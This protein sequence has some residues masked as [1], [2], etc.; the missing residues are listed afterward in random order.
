MTKKNHS[1]M[2]NHISA[3]PEYFFATITIFTEIISLAYVSKNFWEYFVNEQREKYKTPF[4]ANVIR[5]TT[6]MQIVRILYHMFITRLVSFFSEN[7]VIRAMDL[8][9]RFISLFKNFIFYQIIYQIN[10][11][12]QAFCYI[13]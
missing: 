1:H 2:R 4:F 9:K 5:M 12:K 10:M 6:I 3:F 7:M 13:I 8:D 11:Q